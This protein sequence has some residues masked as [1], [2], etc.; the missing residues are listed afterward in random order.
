MSNERF[1][2]DLFYRLA[3]A[4]LRIPPLRE[5]SGDIGLLVDKLL[6]QINQESVGEPGYNYKKVS[7]AAKNLLLQHSWPGNV[8]ELQNTLRRAAI[9]STATVLDVEDLREAILPESFKEDVNLLNRP[10][11]DGFNLIE[12]TD[13]IS[14]HYIARALKEAHGNK[15]KAAQLVGLPNYQTFS[16]WMKKYDVK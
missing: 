9:W 4:V 15:T 7:V 1:R 6:D 16:N 13:K 5:R 2:V 14:R 10:L 8:R 3:V 11:G 12:I